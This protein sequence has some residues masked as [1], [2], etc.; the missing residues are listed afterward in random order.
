MGSYRN[1][2]LR[3]VN[4]PDSPLPLDLTIDPMLPIVM[5]QV[6]IVPLMRQRSGYLE[7]RAFVLC[8][9]QGFVADIC[10]RIQTFF[11]PDARV[12]L[13]YKCLTFRATCSDSSPPRL[14][15]LGDLRICICWLTECAVRRRAG[16]VL[17][18]PYLRVSSYPVRIG[19]KH[20]P[21]LFTRFAIPLRYVLRLVSRLKLNVFTHRLLKRSSTKLV[22][23]WADKTCLL[24]DQ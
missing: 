2:Q 16:E 22:L 14:T 23:V 7:N 8:D 11:P 24:Q 5:L 21:W 18:L 15:D 19:E 20:A 1:R 13:K 10:A 3:V 4:P 12:F 17:S 9:E 6:L